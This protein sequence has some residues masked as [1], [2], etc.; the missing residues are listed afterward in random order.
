MLPSRQ[1][2][3]DPASER[4]VRASAVTK[5][6]LKWSECDPESRATG[7]LNSTCA[8]VEAEFAGGQIDYRVFE[9]QPNE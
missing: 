7:G 2:A 6:S 3:R 1:H 8:V 5:I 4:Q 9:P